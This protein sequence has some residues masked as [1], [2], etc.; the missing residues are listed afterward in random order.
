MK[1]K[2]NSSTHLSTT[3][4][5]YFLSLSFCCP[6]FMQA[7]VNS[8]MNYKTNYGGR[9]K[10]WKIENVHLVRCILYTVKIF[11][12]LFSI[13]VNCSIYSSCVLMVLVHPISADKSSLA[14]WKGKWVCIQGKIRHKSVQI[15]E[16]EATTRWAVVLSVCFSI[17]RSRG[18][19][20]C[21]HVI[22]IFI[23]STKFLGF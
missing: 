18:L 14:H 4:T 8:V 15:F 10:K 7:T 6:S 2:Y 19:K 1:G 9:W 22:F 23:A 12:I 11:G 17:Y 20:L 5:F 16:T 21:L 3:S 13:C